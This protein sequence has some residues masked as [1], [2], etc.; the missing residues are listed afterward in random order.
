MKYKAN[1]FFPSLSFQ[2]INILN[3]EKSPSD[4]KIKL[5]LELGPLS[6]SV[7]E[8][9]KGI[10]N[11]HYLY[12]YIIP[13]NQL[14]ETSRGLSLG[15]R[16]SFTKMVEYA[17]HNNIKKLQCNYTKISLQD[18]IKNN[19][20]EKKS[21]NN[22]YTCFF[23]LEVRYKNPAFENPSSRTGLSIFCFIDSSENSRTS[24]PKE[25]IV[26]EKILNVSAKNLFFIPNTRPAYLVDETMSGLTKGQPYQGSV[27]MDRLGNTRA[28][29]PGRRGM[30][31]KLKILQVEN[32]KI[33]SQQSLE[34]VQNF[35]I[36]IP[37]ME[38]LSIAKAGQ[39]TESVHNPR[40]SKLHL[41][42]VARRNEVAQNGFFSGL[43]QEASFLTED[44]KETAYYR[45]HSEASDDILNNSYCGCVISID[46]YK[47]L[48]TNSNFSPVLDFH[49]RS[50]NFLIIKE[51]VNMT[52]IVD[53]KIYR[54][55]VSNREETRTKLGTK[56][57]GEYSNSEPETLI[58][59]TLENSKKTIN[60]QANSMAEIQQIQFLDFNK[61][62]SQAG[63]ISLSLKDYDLFHNKDFGVYTYIVEITVEDG[64]LK[65]I[66]KIHQN[67]SRALTS[68]SEYAQN[69]SLPEPKNIKTNA[70]ISAIDSYAEASKF[71]SGRRI[72]TV[73]LRK[74]ILPPKYD[75][76]LIEHFVKTLKNTKLTIEKYMKS[77][78]PTSLSIEHAA[79]KSNNQ[80]TK[81]IPGFI[82]AREETNIFH[83]VEELLSVCADPISTENN[84][85]EIPLYSDIF[86]SLKNKN[87]NSEKNA[88]YHPS[89]FIEIEKS[90]YIIQ[91]NSII[92][93]ANK[94]INEF[95]LSQRRGVKKEN[96]LPGKVHTL[97]TIDG[98]ESSPE[99]R[100]RKLDLKLGSY[101]NCESD[102]FMLKGKPEE[103]YEKFLTSN[104]SG[105][106]ISAAKF[107]STSIPAS[108]E[109]LLR[110]AIVDMM[111]DAT[112]NLKKSII[113]SA[114]NSKDEKEFEK[115]L[116]KNYK[117]LI[118]ISKSLGTAYK[119]FSSYLSFQNII[120]ENKNSINFEKQYRT[121]DEEF[122]LQQ[123]EII[124]SPFESELYRAYIIVPGKGKIPITNL[125]TSNIES[126]GIVFVKFENSKQKKLPLINN[127]MML[128]L[129]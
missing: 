126:S 37:G 51:M 35:Q 95:K 72:R 108:A 66:Q 22:K 68:F 106:T 113:D 75:Q 60:H 77:I 84:L 19:K 74:Q 49:R 119:S 4:I 79:E 18:L 61:K 1:S 41:T 105:I 17:G 14:Q 30:G 128:R 7:E 57:R 80:S 124:N 23:E 69:T 65:Y 27:M 123:E 2:K 89:K 20:I 8:H 118:S 91:D 6:K 9:Y 42:S 104:I 88:I 15:N 76:S 62:S 93:L 64:S 31:P 86:G 13:D 33:I 129:N 47:L 3:Y 58:I 28:K 92:T 53:L 109:Q 127:G 38:L 90:R 67:I 25:N 85:E 48:L 100:K 40:I 12:F 102:S 97:E 43:R 36:N 120:A 110:D 116:S 44:T 115:N 55:R 111:P 99:D 24:S 11:S 87:S 16:K 54:K 10:L 63:I 39:T 34:R 121:G 103:F 98:Y 83:N 32:K 70:V 94:Q 96:F 81:A 46:L 101:I 29:I 71:F 52:K 114:Y 112:D 117:E 21:S 78:V 73:D 5:K 50:K 125:D 122:A 45:I 59:E 26:Y 82:Y 56:K 107:S